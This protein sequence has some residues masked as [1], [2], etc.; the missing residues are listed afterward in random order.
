MNKHIRKAKE[1][2]LSKYVAKK[3]GTLNVK[4][5]SAKKLKK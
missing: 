3:F 2:K 4:I 1:K 5:A